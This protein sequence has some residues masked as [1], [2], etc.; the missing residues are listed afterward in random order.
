MAV[1][2]VRPERLSTHFSPQVTSEARAIVNGTA[3]EVRP[4]ER[5][6]RA[7][8]SCL[9]QSLSTQPRLHSS[10]LIFPDI[11]VPLAAISI[12]A[13]LELPG[14]LGLRC[15]DRLRG[16][17]KVDPAVPE[18]PETRPEFDRTACVG[19]RLPLAPQK[20]T[21]LHQNGLASQTLIYPQNT[22]HSPLR[23]VFAF[24][25]KVFPTPTPKTPYAPTQQ[26]IST[27]LTPT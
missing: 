19:P 24:L 8:R 1:A 17:C 2:A 16:R 22:L 23:T 26:L 13:C 20:R 3:Y 27:Q 9:V 11:A 21:C 15:S 12:A 5:A 18:L 10:Y 6:T 25:Q 4:S 14:S 7:S